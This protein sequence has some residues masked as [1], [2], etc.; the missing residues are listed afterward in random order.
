[1]FV[2]YSG[3]YATHEYGNQIMAIEQYDITVKYKREKRN[4]SGFK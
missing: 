2:E 1:M 4:V 3:Q